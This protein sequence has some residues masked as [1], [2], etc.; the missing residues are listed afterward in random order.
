MK[1]KKKIIGMGALVGILALTA[2][3]CARAPAERSPS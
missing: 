2:V 1:D 3:G